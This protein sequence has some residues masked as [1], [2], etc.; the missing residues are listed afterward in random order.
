MAS[1]AVILNGKKTPCASKEDV[2]TRLFTFAVGNYRVCSLHALRVNLTV[3]ADLLVELLADEQK[4][5]EEKR[6]SV[7]DKHSRKTLG[8]QKASLTRMVKRMLLF[9]ESV[10]KSTDVGALIAKTYE[11]VLSLEGK[12]LLPGFGFTNRFKDTI[13]GDPERVSILSVNTLTP[14]R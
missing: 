8:T 6:K 3:A 14:G 1:Y 10:R 5:L 13:H 9:Q 2:V 12:G 4:V 7:N 11:M